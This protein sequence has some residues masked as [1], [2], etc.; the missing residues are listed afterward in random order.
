MGKW[1]GAG[2]G[3][4]IFRWRP[5]VSALIS[6]SNV[7]G[8]DHRFLPSVHLTIHV[9]VFLFLPIRAFLCPFL[10]PSNP[11][12]FYS[13]RAA[14]SLLPFLPS[15]TSGWR[16]SGRGIISPRRRW[17]F[18]ELDSSNAYRTTC[19]LSISRFPPQP[20]GRAVNT[21]MNEARL[22]PVSLPGSIIASFHR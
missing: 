21:S 15:P 2:N 7:S 12:M 17:W 20:I 8:E 22:R 5:I 18:V 4:V 14:A 3:V 11:V 9:S 16:C 19:C 10:H 1:F 6:V 13:C